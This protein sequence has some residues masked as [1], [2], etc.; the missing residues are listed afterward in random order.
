VLESDRYA[1]NRALDY[2]CDVQAFEA[3]FS[4]AT[5]LMREDPAERI[6][7]FRE[8][9]RLY[10]GDHMEDILVGDWHS[11]LREQIRRNYLD[12]M[13][14]LGRLLH[15]TEQISAAAEAL[16]Q[17][18]ERDAYWKAAQRKLMRWYKRLGVYSMTNRSERAVRRGCT[19]GKGGI[20]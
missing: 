10:R 3:A 12:G 11:A 1:L 2:C 16:R 5:Q 7:L 6:N 19:A 8:G 9:N 15:G 14:S 4:R 18:L 20:S 13:M 17:I